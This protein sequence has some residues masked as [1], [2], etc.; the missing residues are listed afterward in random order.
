MLRAKAKHRAAKPHGAFK[1]APQTVNCET[2][3]DL[4]WWGCSICDRAAYGHGCHSLQPRSLDQ[5]R[6][7][8][9][10]LHRGVPLQLLL[11]PGC[12][13]SCGAAKR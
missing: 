2:S 3:P 10:A 12:K 4:G 9:S 6:L 11:A 1:P 8:V 7:L 5:G 13:S